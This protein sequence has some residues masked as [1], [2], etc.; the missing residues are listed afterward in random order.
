MP[1]E[2]SALFEWIETNRMFVD[3]DGGRIGFLY[4]EVEL[5][6]GWTDTERPG[7]KN[8]EYGASG[9]AY[10]HYWF[11]HNRPEVVNRLC[12]FAQTGAEGSVAAF[13]ID[14][15][16]VQR[17]I[18]MGSGSGSVLCYVLANNALDFLRLLA[19]GYDEICWNAEYEY[20][21]NS[22]ENG[23]E[24]YVPPNAKFQEWLI[25]KYGVTIPKRALEIV[26]Y[27]SEIGD[28][29]TQDDFCR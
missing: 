29:K 14:D 12:V 23:N 13:W 2:Q 20:P 6:A 17:I 22:P 8:I 4:P 19:I 21:P 5:K 15:N 25:G 27:T 24:F 16:S 28:Q 7:G 3:N 26:E 18:H 10:V 9:N 1:T 11:G